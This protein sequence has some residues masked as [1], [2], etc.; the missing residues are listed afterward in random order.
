MRATIRLYIAESGCKNSPQRKAEGSRKL[1][2][3]VFVEGVHIELIEIQKL[4]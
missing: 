4:R 2:I 3:I 1:F